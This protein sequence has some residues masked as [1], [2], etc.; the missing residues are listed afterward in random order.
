MSQQRSFSVALLAIARVNVQAETSQ[1]I[2]AQQDQETNLKKAC[3]IRV[4]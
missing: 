3:Q 1:E 4:D 2:P